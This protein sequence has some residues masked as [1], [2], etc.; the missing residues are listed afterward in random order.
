MPTRLDFAKLDL[1]DALDLAIL[2][3]NEA[4]ERYEMFVTQLGRRFDGDAASI[5]AEMREAEKK[6]GMDLMAR[7]EK[8]FG[9][10]PMRVSPADLFDVEAPGMGAIRA[11]MSARQAL[12]VALKAEQ[13][14]L[15][16][17]ADALPHVT[18]P[19]VKALFE[20]LRLEEVEHVRMVRRLIEKLPEDADLEIEE[21]DE[22]PML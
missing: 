4:F 7:R 17:Y 10:A 12:D 16:F 11:T 8:L 20:E 6:H 15:D 14:A 21:E 2:I 22:A 3:E 13:R 1:M 18:D 19:D 9:K 5:F